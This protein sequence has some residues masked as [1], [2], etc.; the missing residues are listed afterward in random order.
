MCRK[1]QPNMVRPECEKARKGKNEE[2]KNK[3]LVI[4]VGDRE[5]GDAMS[6]NGD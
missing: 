2:V 6:H 5:A 1:K 3:S 4:R